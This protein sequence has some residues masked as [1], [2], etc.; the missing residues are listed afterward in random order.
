MLDRCLRSV[1][2]FVGITVLAGLQIAPSICGAIDT[3]YDAMDQIPP[4]Q[5][6]GAAAGATTISVSTNVSTTG[7]GSISVDTTFSSGQTYVDL[8]W[9]SLG[10]K[11]F[12]QNIFQLDFRT[13][14]TNAKLLWRL[15]SQSGP[16]Y[17]VLGSASTAN[18]FT[19]LSFFS[20]NFSGNTANLTNINLIQLRF[21]GDNIPVLPESV[22]YFVDN[23]RIDAYRNVDT[24]QSAT[25]TNVITGTGG[26]YKAG[27]GLLQVAST[28]NYTGATTVAA[29]ELQ[30]NGSISSSA[31]SVASGAKLSGVGTVGSATIGSGATISPGTS[32]GE[33]TINGDLT[34]GGGGSYD[35]EILSLADGAGTGWDLIAVGDELL[36]SSLS[37]T[38]KFNINLFSLSGANTAGALANFNYATNYT[39]KI[40]GATNNIA[41]FNA[42]NFNLSTGGFTAYN[43]LHGGFFSLAVDGG[44]LNLLYSS[45]SAVPEPGTWAAGLLLVATSA[46]IARHRKSSLA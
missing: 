43:N 13:T 3:V 18:S 28:N 29:G 30:V 37:S 35:W 39:W 17:E 14:D 27:D 2:T 12:S 1:R 4:W 21:I 24:G 40:L 34:W 15:G 44:D 7:L 23:L 45:G 20:S 22:N 46:F 36:F 19:N 41:G 16:V 11:D 33:L 25:L 26:L 31:V 38:N 42:A 8:Y 32:P 10:V 6:G 9:D 5:K